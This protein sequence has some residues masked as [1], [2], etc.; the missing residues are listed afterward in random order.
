M[1]ISLIPSSFKIISENQTVS[2]KTYNKILNMSKNLNNAIINWYIRTGNKSD[3]N[4][5]RPGFV[6]DDDYLQFIECFELLK[7]NSTDIKNED[8]LLYNFIIYYYLLV[9]VE[10][11]ILEYS[12]NIGALSN[13][14]SK[15]MYE[16]SM[17]HTEWA[18][19]IRRKLLNFNKNKFK[20]YYIPR[21]NP[22]EQHFLKNKSISRQLCVN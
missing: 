21:F 4:E 14:N 13:Y 8:E 5:F 2:F 11:Y 20:S 22:Y 7:K 10:Y 3:L 18:S 6:N 12:N 17:N 19:L 15:W 16:F 1:S 9:V